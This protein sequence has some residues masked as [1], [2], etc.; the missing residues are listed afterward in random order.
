MNTLCIVIDEP[1]NPALG[2]NHQI[3]REKKEASQSMGMTGTGDYTKWIKLSGA[4]LLGVFI[5][6]R[7]Q[8]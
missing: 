2:V 8:K 1:I 3:E 5:W 7:I 6:N 4:I